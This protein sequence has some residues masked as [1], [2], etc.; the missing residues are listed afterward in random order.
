MSAEV[1]IVIRPAVLWERSPRVVEATV[2]VSVRTLKRWSAEEG[3]TVHTRGQ[4]TGKRDYWFTDEVLAFLRATGRT[5][6]E[7]TTQ[8]D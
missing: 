2:G 3:L 8:E 7:T 1:P 6:H 5:N 4:R